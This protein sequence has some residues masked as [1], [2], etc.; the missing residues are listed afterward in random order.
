V[1]PLLVPESRDTDTR[2]RDTVA[3]AQQAGLVHTG[4]IVVIT[5]GVPVGVPGR[6]NLIKVQCVGEDD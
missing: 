2:L 1:I 6:T 3:A 5:A 4:D